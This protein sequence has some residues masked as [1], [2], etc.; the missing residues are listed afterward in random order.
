MRRMAGRQSGASLSGMLVT[1]AVIGFIAYAAIKLTPI[2]LE[3]FNVKASLNSLGEEMRQGASAN[4]IRGELMKRLQL[5][6]VKSVRPED[7]EIK[8]MGRTRVVAVNYEVRT[9]FYGNLYLVMAFD[10]STVLADR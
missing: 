7:V 4:E 5:N 6:D 3:S 9:R 10:E 2:Y 1:V 8:A